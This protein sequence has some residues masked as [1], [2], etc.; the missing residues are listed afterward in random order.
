MGLQLA[1]GPT[2]LPSPSCPLQVIG[3]LEE[4]H[5][6]QNGINHPGITALAQAFAINPLL[7]VINLNDNTFTE[8][9][10]VAMAKVRCIDTGC[11]VGSGG[12]G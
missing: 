1:L 7:R 10:A 6:P 3:T 2:S 9:G 4:V 11:D 8:K 5:M 12:L